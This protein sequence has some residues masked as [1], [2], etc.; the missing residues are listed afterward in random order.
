MATTESD[1]KEDLPE[2]ADVL[3]DV[4]FGGAQLRALIAGGSTWIA[5]G[6]ELLIVSSVS[7][8]VK[9]E[10]HLSPTESGLIV[11]MVFV[12]MLIGNLVGGQFA[13]SV[14]RRFPIVMLYGGV[15]FFSVAS[16]FA[17]GILSLAIARFFVGLFCGIGGAAWVTLSVEIV[18]SNRRLHMICLGEI[19]FT[20]GELWS[21]GLIFLEDPTM[22]SL[23][24]RKMIL[25]A[26]IPSFVL[27]ILSYLLLIESPSFLSVQGRHKEAKAVVKTMF[28]QNGFSEEEASKDFRPPKKGAEETGRFLDRLAIICGPSFYFTTFVSCFSCFTLN[29]FFYGGL[30]CFAAILPDMDTGISAGTSLLLGA[31]QEFPGNIIGLAVAIYLTRRI[32][33]QVYLVG[34]LLGLILFAVAGSYLLSGTVVSALPQVMLQIGLQSIK[35]FTTMGFLV[36]FC[37]AAEIYKTS[38]RGTGTAF[39]MAVGRIGAMSSPMIY[40]WLLSYTNDKLSFIYFMIVLNV[41]NIVLVHFVSVE[42]SGRKLQDDDEDETSPLMSR[43]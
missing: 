13:D 35:A 2:L 40:Q 14:G 4:G 11:S 19:L 22:T 43:P 15:F 7:A 27:G 21:I 38:I 17:Q 6:A 26:S 39:S 33:I 5:D 12:G 30:Y 25:L 28:L 9:K 24:W 32:G 8:E 1:A 37:F 16:A 36:V 42:T 34:N 23:N 20:F 3:E 41:I 10:W 29:T 18:P 31:L